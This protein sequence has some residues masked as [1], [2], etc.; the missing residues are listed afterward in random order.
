MGEEC[1][2]ALERLHI[3]L[4]GECEASM[5]ATIRS[6]LDDCPPC[7]DRADF[8][9]EL[10]AVIARKCKDAAPHGLVDRVIDILRP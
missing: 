1:R 8:E 3:Y 2:E 7:L 6:H 4:D 9:R 10:R 5:A